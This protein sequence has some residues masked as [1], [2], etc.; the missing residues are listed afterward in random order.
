MAE[1]HVR[2]F[3]AMDG[4]EVVGIYSRTYSKA[5]TLAKKYGINSVCN[6]ISELYNIT[7]SDAV[8]IAVSETST[9]DICYEAFKFQWVALVEK[10][11]GH[12]LEEAI[13]ITEEA[14]KTNSKVFVALNRR[15]YSSTKRVLNELKIS[16]QPRLI[17]VMDQQDPRAARLAGRPEEVVKNWMYANSIHLIDYLKLL[18]RGDITSVDRLVKWIPDTPQFVIA[19]ISFSSGDIGLYEAIWNGPG[20]WAVTVTTQ[21]KRWE[22]RPLEQAAFQVYGSRQLQPIE[23]DIM[24]SKFKPGFYSQA[25][26]LVKAVQGLP[27]TLVSAQEALQS[28]KLVEEIYA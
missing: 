2:A 7:N 21:E 14:K 13:D 17:H 25:E 9:K 8:I 16:D 19:K 4:V 28:M 20:P 5:I 12:N 6:S 26:E 24:D 22:L 10:P 1:E 11:L 27:H 3:A 23:T 18:G 15:Q